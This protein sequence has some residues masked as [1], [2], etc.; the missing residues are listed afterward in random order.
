MQGFSEQEKQF[1]L[2]GVIE[3]I[4]VTTLDKQEHELVIRFKIPYV[5]DTFEWK[6]TK[7]RGQGYILGDGEKKVSVDIDTLKKTPRLKS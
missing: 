6:N 7:A 5:N 4:S 1:F 2:R 3:K